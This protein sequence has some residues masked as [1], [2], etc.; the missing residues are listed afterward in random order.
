MRH[1]TR[2]TWGLAAVS[3][4]LGLGPAAAEETEKATPNPVQL[5]V[6][7]FEAAAPE[8]GEPMPNVEIHDAQGN[9]IWLHD[10][11]KGHYTV[12]VL[13]CLT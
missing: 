4:C 9:K 7:R 6:D 12:L 1:T 11:L 5:V 2:M 3:L 10:V 8:V 13:G